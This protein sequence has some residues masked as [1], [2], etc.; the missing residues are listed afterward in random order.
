MQRRSNTTFFSLLFIPWNTLQRKTIP[1]LG[2]L[3]F[4]NSQC[5]YP[6]F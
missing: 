6:G 2:I 4:V 3:F 1:L 5:K